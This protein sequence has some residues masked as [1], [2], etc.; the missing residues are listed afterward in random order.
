MFL[1]GY[2]ELW[3]YKVLIGKPLDLSSTCEYIGILSFS[4]IYNMV[5][6]LMFVFGIFF[7]TEVLF[8]FPYNFFF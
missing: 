4:F 2:F 7:Y 8:S 1:C 5:G 6:M 3:V